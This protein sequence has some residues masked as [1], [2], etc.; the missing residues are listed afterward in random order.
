MKNG[1]AKDFSW[2]VSA[3]NYLKVFQKI[4]TEKQPAHYSY[5]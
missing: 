2:D 3:E 4:L 5:D 1:M